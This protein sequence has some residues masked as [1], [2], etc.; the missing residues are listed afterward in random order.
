MLRP[1]IPAVMS[2]QNASDVILF[3]EYETNALSGKWRQQPACAYS[4]CPGIVQPRPTANTPIDD[5]VVRALWPPL[6]ASELG[7]SVTGRVTFQSQQPY[8]EIQ[9]YA[10]VQSELYCQTPQPDSSTQGR[11]T[12]T[13]EIT[14]FP[15]TRPTPS[16]GW[17]LNQTF[18][19][20]EAI[21]VI[22]L[23]LLINGIAQA[24]QEIQVQK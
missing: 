5:G 15:A 21:S 17:D 23:R 12:Y 24:V 18:A 20:D 22:K 1:V 16:T 14:L 7:A 10:N 3:G 8:P 11:N 4:S 9:V 6:I 19:L 13:V 2:K